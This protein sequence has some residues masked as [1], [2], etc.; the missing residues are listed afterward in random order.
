M[1][2]IS[3]WLIEGV[4]RLF[5]ALFVR[6]RVV[7]RENLPPRG[8]Y[9]IIANH[10]SLFEVPLIGLVLPMLPIYFA[11]RELAEV[12]VMRWA[13]WA[14][15]T[16]LV[17]RGY[18][19]R[20]A[21]FRSYEVLG[22]GRVL[23]IFPEGGITAETVERA[24]AGLS[25]MDMTSHNS[26]PSAKL[27]H[28]RAGAAYIASKTQ[29][30]IVPIALLGTEKIERNVRRWRRTEVEVRVG[31]PFGPLPA[32]D[33]EQVWWEKRREL[34]RLSDEMMRE[35]AALMPVENRGVYAGGR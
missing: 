6:R 5:C 15:E 32:L 27:I 7:G 26:R 21:F 29:V 9:I 10:F 13:F 8:P 14:N 11:A 28:G 4:L 24:S 2:R 34:N 17:R 3:L 16:I 18:A 20:Q 25:T 23:V 30:P 33:G 31:R 19:D 35:I 22:N 12:G 1:R